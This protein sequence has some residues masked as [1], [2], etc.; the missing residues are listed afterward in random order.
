M[1]EDMKNKIKELLIALRMYQL[2]FLIINVINAIV[3]IYTK[4]YIIASLSAIAVIIILF[5]LILNIQEYKEW[6]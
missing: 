5:S 4:N 6:I 2:G 3:N 1:G